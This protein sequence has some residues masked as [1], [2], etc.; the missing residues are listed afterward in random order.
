MAPSGAAPD[1][2]VLATLETKRDACDYLTSALAASGATVETLDLGL[3]A[4]GTSLDGAAKVAAM[5][6]ATDRAREI[7]DDRLSRGARAVAGL[8]GGTGA[9]MVLGVLRTLPFG[10]PKFLITTLPFDPRPHLVETDIVIVPTMADIMGLNATLRTVLD[11]AAA[12]IGGAAALSASPA[13]AVAPGVALTAM[14]ITTPGIDQ[15]VARLR[16]GGIES[17]VFHAVGYGGSAMQAW[18]AR[19][20]FAG[21]IDFTP[22]EITRILFGGPDAAK[23]Q[24]FETAAELDLPQIIVP[25][26]L[27]LHCL[28][29]LET[30]APEMR[31]RQHYRHSAAFTHV[32][33][34]DE[35]M[36]ECVRFLCTR[37][38]RSRGQLRIMV[39]MSGFSTEDRAGGAIEAPELRKLFHDGMRDG[40]DRTDAVIAVDAHINDP[41]FAEAVTET[42][43]ALRMQE[44]I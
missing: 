5:R 30:L 37:L 7:V 34:S 38:N 42:Y 28:G 19:G 10:L 32:R 39:P 22:H 33:L 43:A 13:P 12:A 20:A 16:A 18:L 11:T 21:V 17:T 36:A 24:R 44:G 14:G 23:S 31:A 8:G 1:I 6:A 29:P 3:N 2:L 41:G 4:G 35:E 25:G 27:N 26:G 9:Q 15:V 40:L